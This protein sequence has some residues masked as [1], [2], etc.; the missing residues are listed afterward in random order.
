MMLAL[1]AWRLEDFSDTMTDGRVTRP[2]TIFVQAGDAE[3]KKQLSPGEVSIIYPDDTKG[4]HKSLPDLLD[5]IPGV[6][7]RCVTGT[8]QYTTARIRASAPSQVEYLFDGISYKTGSESATD[9]STIPMSNVHALRSIAARHLR[10]FLAR[11]S[12]ARST[13]SPSGRTR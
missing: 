8:G 4:E 10:A 13:S 6:Y 1:P 9:L 11:R 3:L 12:A 5:Q 7:V 2:G